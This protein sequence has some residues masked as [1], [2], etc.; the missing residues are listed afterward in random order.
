MFNSPL[1]RVS[2]K[3]AQQ[4]DSPSEHESEEDDGEDHEEDEDSESQ[5]SDCDETSDLGSDE[6][7]EEDDEDSGMNRLSFLVIKVCM[8]HLALR[9]NPFDYFPSVSLVLS[10][11]LSLTF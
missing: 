5:E 3:P 2:S 6:D 10:R 7:D 11:S 4:P 8:L 9:L 1:Y